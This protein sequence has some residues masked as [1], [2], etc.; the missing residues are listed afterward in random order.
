MAMSKV[1]TNA[2]RVALFLLLV[3][4]I[5][6]AT[7]VFHVQDHI[8]DILD[9]IE[10][11]RVAGS[12]SF[13][14]LYAL[15]TVLPVPASV[16]SL[17]AGA[18]F[19]LVP[20]TI[21]VWSGATIG[22]VGCL[23][24]GRCLLREW[25]ASLANKYPVWQAIEGAIR[26]EGWKMVMLLRLSPILPFALLNYGLSVTPISA[27]TY[28]WASAVGII[29]GTLLYVYLGS[30]ANDIGEL[31][32]GRRKVSPVI[33]IVSAVLSG[34]FIVAAF[35]VISVRAKRAIS[36]RLAEER[37]LDEQGRDASDIEEAVPLTGHSTPSNR[38]T[39]V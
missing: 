20:G 39:H 19:G 7:L 3:A 2:L 38:M 27:W 5:L 16:L 32:S 10:E 17:G 22:L 21:L 23:F 1:A 11:H 9:W 29:P 4:A 33:T 8:G 37:L 35:V 12:V 13:V 28:T 18:I 24:V 30:L 34:V 6:V 14:A 15:F 26:D 36:R 25:V 31:V